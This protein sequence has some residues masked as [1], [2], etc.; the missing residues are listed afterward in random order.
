MPDFKTISIIAPGLLG[1][2]ILQAL[3]KHAPEIR[4][5]VWA[6]REETRSQVLKQ[7]LADTV[8]GNLSEAVADSDLII[9]CTPIQAM[10]ETTRN[11]LPALKPSALVTD[12]GSVKGPVHL[13]LAPLLAK[14]CHWIGSHPMA[15]S[16]QSGLEAAR[17][18]L[19]Q[20]ARTI[21]T[22]DETA[23][24]AAAAKLRR[25]WELLGCSVVTLSPSL[26]DTY[27]A[28]ISH[29]PHLVAALLV[30]SVSQESLQV[31]G[32]GFRDTS[33]VAAGP[34]DMW[35]EIFQAN[36]PAV[37]EA[38][39]QFLEEAQKALSKMESGRCPE[40]LDLLTSACQKRRSLP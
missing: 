5:N 40:L 25:F 33:R 8:T 6:R 14:K 9:L 32:P 3:R 31:A 4:L 26:H 17:A 30:H 39:K 16:E 12:V 27:V 24:P 29:L 22:P 19:F 11:F 13:A 1:G 28:Q 38:M 2:S 23:D 35:V 36:H 18:D 10:E 20:G 37:A 34:P 15:G 7:R 21:I